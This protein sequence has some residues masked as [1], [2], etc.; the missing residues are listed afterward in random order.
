[1]TSDVKKESSGQGEAGFLRGWEGHGL[2]ERD[3]VG[4][5]VVKAADHRVK[6]LL[7]RVSIS[8]FTSTVV[9]G[10]GSLRVGHR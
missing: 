8:G 1:M 2:V 9:V 3:A 5:A 7:C 6:R 4:E 10:P